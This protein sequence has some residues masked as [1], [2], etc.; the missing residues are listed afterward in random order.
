MKV[1]FVGAGP[2]DPEL[3]TRKAARLLETCRCCV[4]AG[5]LV[6]PEVVGIILVISILLI[7]LNVV[8]DILYAL[9]DPRVRQ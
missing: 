7:A 1:V 4:Y 5:S 3:L 9:L 2:G 8:V 6:S